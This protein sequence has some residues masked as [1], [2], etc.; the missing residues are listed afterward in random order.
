MAIL[1]VAL[2]AAVVS[3]FVMGLRHHWHG[4]VMSRYSNEHDLRFNRDDPFGIPL[5]YRRFALISCGHSPRACNVTHGRVAGRVVRAFDFRYEIG[6]G[7]LRVTRRYGVVVV[8]M[9]TPDHNVLMWNDSDAQHAPLEVRQIDG[10][11]GC[12]S[13]TGDA[14]LAK[15]LAGHVGPLGAD[16]LSMQ[17]RDGLLMLYLPAKGRKLRNYTDWMSEGIELAEQLGTGVASAGDASD[18]E[19]AGDDITRDQQ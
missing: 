1:I 11:V 4:R 7:T 17:A 8:D 19:P 6:H 16:G 9:E 5:V 13:F 15:T 10:H 3:F 18:V 14:D 2:T 12:W